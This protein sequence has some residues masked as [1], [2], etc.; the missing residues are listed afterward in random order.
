MDVTCSSRIVVEKIGGIPWLEERYNVTDDL[1]Q[2]YLDSKQFVD[3]R[4]GR[5][6]SDTNQHHAQR[7]ASLVDRIRRNKK[8]V[9]VIIYELEDGSW[10]IDDG[11][12]RIRAYYFLDQDITFTL[13]KPE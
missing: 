5:Y 10:C 6:D 12:H 7:I 13:Y 4:Y 2:Q 3:T 11:L 1:I 8:L 9:S